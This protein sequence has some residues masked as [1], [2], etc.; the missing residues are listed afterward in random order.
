MISMTQKANTMIAYTVSM[1]NNFS[2]I[3]FKS[4]PVWVAFFMGRAFCP[5][6]SAILNNKWVEES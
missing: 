2:L 3:Y 5:E 4:Y 1:Q 6:I